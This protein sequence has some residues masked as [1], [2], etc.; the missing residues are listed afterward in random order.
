MDLRT[1]TAGLRGGVAVLVLA[2][3]LAACEDDLAPL[4]T[5]TGTGAVEGLVFFDASEDGIYDPADGD[6]AV[7]GVTVAVQDRGTGQTFSGGTAQSGSDGRFR[8]EGLPAGTHDLLIDETTVPEGINICQNPLRVTVYLDETRFAPV[9]GRPGCLITIA[10][11]KDAPV[12]EFVIVD[13]IVTAFPGQIE[14]GYTYIQDENDG[15]FIFG[16]SLQGRG[17]AV[18]DQLEVGGTTTIFSGQFELENVEFRRLV[19]DVATPEPLL[20]TT[21][22]LAASGADTF[23]HLQNFFVRVEGA[24]L[25]TAFGGGGLNEQNGIIDDGSGSL[26]IRVDNGVVADPADLNTVF[27]VGAC[28]DINGF[29]VNFNGTGQIFPRSLDDVEEVPCT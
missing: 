23:D 5:I 2:V 26:Q 17:I 1:K 9:Q 15:L 21:A 7:Q 18:G 24:K 27:T 13:G 29:G 3:S 6:Y 11:A 14:S 8:V 12:G 4:F 16:T 19:E 20:V 28:Y 25:T 10:E 22:E